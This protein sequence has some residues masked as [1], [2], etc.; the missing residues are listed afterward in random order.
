[1]LAHPHSFSINLFITYLQFRFWLH[2]I[3]FDIMSLDPFLFI[4]ALEREL[5]LIVQIKNAMMIDY[6]I[7]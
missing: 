6:F 7:V 3:F 5:V 2:E 4:I 1:M